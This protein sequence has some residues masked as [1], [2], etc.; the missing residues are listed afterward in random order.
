M[1][2][3]DILPLIECLKETCWQKKKKDMGMKEGKGE[4][5]AGKKKFAH[6]ASCRESSNCQSTADILGS[7]ILCYL[8]EMRI[9]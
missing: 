5:W 1:L 4:A 2:I 7:E 3:E 8:L 6:P 9:T